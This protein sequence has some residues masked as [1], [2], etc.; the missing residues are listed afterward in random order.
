MK[1]GELLIPRNPKLR[2]LVNRLPGLFLAILAATALFLMPGCSIRVRM[3]YHPNIDALEKT[4]RVGESTQSDVVLALGQP[5]G[6]GQL[7]FPTDPKPRTLWS[8]YYGEG[9]ME[10]ARNLFLFVFFA[11]DRYDGYMWFSSLKEDIDRQLSASQTVPNAV[12]TKTP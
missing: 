4:L 1:T 5:F 8:Y 6:K 2:D 9:D 11:Q 3:G 7:M 10:D 12:K